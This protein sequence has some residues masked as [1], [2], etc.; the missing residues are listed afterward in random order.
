MRSIIIL[1]GPRTSGRKALIHEQHLQP[2][3]IDQDALETVFGEIVS[4][5]TGGHR[6]D[7]YQ[8]NRARTRVSAILNEKMARGNFIIFQPSDTGAPYS[9][10]TAS[11]ADRMTATVIEQARKYGYTTHILDFTNTLDAVDLETRRAKEGSIM[12]EG[13][14][15]R[16]LAHMKRRIGLPTGADIHWHDAKTLKTSLTSLVEPKTL[17]FSQWKNVVVIGDIHGCPKTLA[18]LTDNYEVRKDTAYLFLGDYIN[19]GPDSGEVLRVLIERF[20]PHQNCHFLTGNHEAGLAD[21]AR[22]DTVHKKVFLTSGLPSIQNAN[23]TRDDAAEFLARTRDAAQIHWNGLDIL[24]THGGLAC[25]PEA[26]ALFSSEHFQHGTDGARFDVDR[27]WAN[28]IASGRIPGPDQLIQVHGH[29]NPLGLPI[30]AAHGS[31]NLE[32]GVDCGREMRAL[33]LSPSDGGYEARPV[34]IP[35]QDIVESKPGLEV[36]N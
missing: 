31:Y 28:N 2:W 18:R 9:R 6:V 19:K 3:L 23:L 26:L 12:K 21:W 25:P 11:A 17:D 33:V 4:D 35:N 8:R 15:A 14:A 1:R 10:S 30:K 36:V 32:N 20:M 5:T 24:A 13:T 22:G 16:I 27:A 34:C 29:R 7:P